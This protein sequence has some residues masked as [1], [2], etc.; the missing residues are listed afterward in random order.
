M[1]RFTSRL[2]QATSAKVPKVPKPV[3]P[4]RVVPEGV[5]INKL[6]AISPELSDLMKL[7]RPGEP[8]RTTSKR[9]DVTKI[10]WE[11]IKANKL[12]DPNDGRT[13]LPDE[14]LKSLLNPGGMQ[15]HILLQE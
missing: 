13:I 7:A 4:K 10:V 14:K 11:Y 5:G 3:K 2:L 9:S 6:Y 12:Q 8:A 1:F 15:N